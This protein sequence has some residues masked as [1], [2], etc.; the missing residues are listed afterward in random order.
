VLMIQGEKNGSVSQLGFK[1]MKSL[2]LELRKVQ[3][4][5]YLT[6]QR[7]EGGH[8]NGIRTEAIVPGNSVLLA[9]RVATRC[10]ELCSISATTTQLQLLLIP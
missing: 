7:F 8:R 9:R 1:E 10:G 4:G 3:K 2:F 6:Y 5:L